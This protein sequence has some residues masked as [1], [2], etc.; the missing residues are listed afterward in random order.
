MLRAV[1]GIIV[2]YTLWTAIWL[3]GNAVIFSDIADSIRRGEPTTRPG[4]YVGVLV[5]SVVCSLAAGASAGAIAGRRA[6]VTLAS[7]LL[8]TGVGVQIGAW[9]MMPT[10]YHLSFLALLMPVTL[11]GG[12]IGRRARPTSQS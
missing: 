2:G 11:L 9:N 5:L 3:G 4:P 6:P 7:L 8:L 10:W 1:I 12:I